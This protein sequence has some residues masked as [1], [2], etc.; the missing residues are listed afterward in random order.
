MQRLQVLL[1]EALGLDHAHRGPAHG[2]ANSGRVVMVVLVAVDVGLDLARRQQ[3]HRM[4]QP[5]YLAM[6]IVRSAAGFH[7]NRAGLELGEQLQ[8]AFTPDGLAQDQL[9]APIDSVQIENLLCDIHPDSSN[10]HSG[11]S[12]SSFR[13]S[14]CHRWLI[15]KPLNAGWVH[16]IILSAAKDLARQ[17][18]PHQH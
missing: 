14:R 4:S 6:P 17:R 5:A 15:M 3:L 2:L 12:R 8:Q 11:R 13:W 16:L 7:S 10:L 1:R 9:A 18:V